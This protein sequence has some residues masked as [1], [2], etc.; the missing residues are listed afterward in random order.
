MA[1]DGW[2]P[3][4][5]GMGQP[6]AAKN[7]PS[8]GLVVPLALPRPLP[9]SGLTHPSPIVVVLP[10]LSCE[11]LLSPPVFYLRGE[12]LGEGDRSV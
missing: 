8:P 1:S 11:C 3:G 2:R 12:P 7:C 6:H 5:L 4:E 10:I 9:T